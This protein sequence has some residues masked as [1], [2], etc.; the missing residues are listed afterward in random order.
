[1]KIKLFSLFLLTI[2]L[3]GICKPLSAQPVNAV[4]DQPRRPMQ[5]I[6]LGPDDKLAFPVAPEG[7][8]KVRENIAKGKIETIEYASKTIFII[9]NRA[10][11]IFRFGKT[12]CINFRN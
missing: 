11:T 3:I 4:A 9:S 1:M 6:V 7:F 5:P 2:L 8:D 12:I 10:N